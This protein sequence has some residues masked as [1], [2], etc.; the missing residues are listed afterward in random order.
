MKSLVMDA[1][2][3]PTLLSPFVYTSPFANVQCLVLS[4]WLL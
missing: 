3:C 4:I 2:V 1:A